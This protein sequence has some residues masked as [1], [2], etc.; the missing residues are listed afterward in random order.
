VPSLA[1]TVGTPQELHSS[2]RQ[3]R[4]T[5]G[6]VSPGAGRITSI[7]VSY[8][9]GTKQVPVGDGNA[10][11]Y[12]TVVDGLTNGR[13]HTFTATVCNSSRL[14]SSSTPFT[15]TPYGAPVVQAPVLSVTGL[16]VTVRVAPVIRDF[17]P[18][19]TTCTLSVT[20]ADP[21]TPQQKSVD[22]E[23]DVLTFTGRASAGYTATET[24]STD[25]VPDGSAPSN[26][27]ITGAAPPTVP[28]SPSA[29]SPLASG[30]E[31]A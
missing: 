19:R 6:N 25:D 22:P 2:D 29:S 27:V 17:H 15:F 23:G 13:P 12:L 5:I 28:S 3:A 8:E 24:C 31:G 14:C 16:V 20:P 10:T 9:T 26:T 11:S 7:T 1:R 4:L 30:T 21:G 18:G